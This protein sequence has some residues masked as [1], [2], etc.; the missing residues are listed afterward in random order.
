MITRNIAGNWTAALC[1]VVLLGSFSKGQA[2]IVGYEVVV[3]TA[4]YGANTPTPDDAFDPNGELDGYVSY[5]VYATF[6][7]P[8]D[9]LSAVFADTTALPDGGAMGFD[10]DCD[11]FNPVDDSMVLSANNSSLLWSIEPMLEYDSFWTIGKLSYDEPGQNA[12]FVSNP[13]LGGGDVCGSAVG[14]GSVFVIGSPENAIAG[15]DLRIVIARVTTCGNWALNANVQTF[16]EGDPG[17]ASLYFLDAD[18]GGAIE[19]QDPC[20]DYNQLDAGVVGNEIFCAGALATVELQFL[21]LDSLVEETQYTVVTSFDGFESEYLVGEYSTNLF[22]GLDVGEY[23]AYVENEYGCLDT[24]TFEVVN[25]DLVETPFGIDMDSTFWSNAAALPDTVTYSGGAEFPLQEWVNQPDGLNFYW[26][27]GFVDQVFVEGCGEAEIWVSRDSAQMMQT[28]T[29]F[30][31]LSGS[32]E[33]GIDFLEPLDQIIMEPG[34]LMKLIQL[35]VVP[36]EL[37]EGVEDVVLSQEFINSCGDTALSSLRFLILDPIPLT[38]TPID[39]SC[40][41]DEV[42]TFAGFSDITGLGPIQYEWT[43]LPLDSVSSG[44]IADDS[45]LFA[46][47]AMLNEEGA[48]IPNQ[49]IELTLIDQCGNEETF[50]QELS[51]AFLM[52]GQFCIDS[53]FPFPMFNGQ[54]PVQD[55]LFEGMSLLQD[56]ILTDT[57]SIQATLLANGFWQ[58]DSLFTGSDDWAGELTLIDSCGRF[59]TAQIVI[60]EYPCTEGCTDEV[61]CNYLGD[62]GIEDGSCEYPGDECDDDDPST[63]GELLNEDC[64]CVMPVDVV[65]EASNF[66]SLFPNP[67]RGQLFVRSNLNQGFVRVISMDGRVVHEDW[68]SDL[69]PGSEIILDLQSGLYIVELISGVNRLS[70]PIVLER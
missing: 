25:T 48:P 18:G 10:S 29:V 19:V 34:V 30:L 22:D 12:Q 15:D 26:N 49:V 44:E 65:A 59:S 1:L 68:R 43:T 66:I 70:Q 47:F 3:D 56:S 20:E 28:D 31:T 67:S 35:N 5:L 62:A 61:A 8:T 64:E 63:L 38:A 11:C 21:G 45:L 17:N 46:P 55:V 36:D 6:T 16:I 33:S 39:L 40:E 42:S 60:L 54:L 13:M 69:N 32:A 27:G 52:P 23:R 57:L 2:Q 14:D 37:A 50:E 53:V 7:N 51:R 9:V 4:F 58:I 24:T 41:G